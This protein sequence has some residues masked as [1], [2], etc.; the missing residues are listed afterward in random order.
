[1]FNCTFS[2]RPIACFVAK[3]Y[4]VVDGVKGDKVFINIVSSESI[5]QPSKTVSPEVIFSHFEFNNADEILN[6]LCKFDLILLTEVCVI[7]TTFIIR[8]TAI[9]SFG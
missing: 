5:M 9:V 3:T 7:N 1:M 6:G 8:D 4:K 2:L